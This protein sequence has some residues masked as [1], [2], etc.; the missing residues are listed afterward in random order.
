MDPKLAYFVK[1]FFHNVS[2]DVLDTIVMQYKD[3]TTQATK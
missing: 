2:R 3:T 1:M